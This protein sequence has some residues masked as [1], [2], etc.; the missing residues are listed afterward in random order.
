[1]LSL[2]ID[3]FEFD[4]PGSE[5]SI[6]IDLARQSKFPNPDVVTF[7]TSTVGVQV[8]TTLPE[9]KPFYFVS[10]RSRVSK[11]IKRF[12]NI[13]IPLHADWLT[14]QLTADSWDQTHLV[15]SAPGIF[16]RYQWSTSA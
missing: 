9:P 11:Y 3:Q 10:D 12:A 4:D 2:R 6:E 16:I 14:H 13:E 15:I 5:E 7:I 8:A 1:M